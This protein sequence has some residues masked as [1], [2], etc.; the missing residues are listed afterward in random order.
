MVNFFHK[1]LLAF[2]LVLLTLPAWAQ[3]NN[4]PFPL[5]GQNASGAIVTAT[6]GTTAISEAN[7]YAFVVNVKD[8]GAKGDGST[9]DT[10]AINAAVTAAQNQLVTSNYYSQ[11]GIPGVYLPPGNYIT[12]GI[13]ISQPIRLYGDG[14]SAVTIT[15]K[16]GSNGSVIKS[17][18]NPLG[19]LSTWTTT[20][21]QFFGFSIN[22]NS[23][24]QTGTS[25]GIE[26]TNAP[27][28]VG[29]QYGV[30]ANI[31]NVNIQDALT[32]GVYVGTNRN[33]GTIDK[34]IVNYAQSDC[35]YF[36]GVSDWSVS[37]S[38]LG[39]CV[40]SGIVLY[41]ASAIT[42]GNDAIYNNGTHG[43]VVS[44][45]FGSYLWITGSTIG[46]NEG[47]GIH[48][49]PG[50]LTSG[51]VVGLSNVHLTDNSLANNNTNSHIYIRNLANMSL[52]NVWFYYQGTGNNVKYLIDNDNSTYIPVDNLMY[53]T[54]GGN[55]AYVTAAFG[56]AAYISGSTNPQGGIQNFNVP[57]TLNSGT[58]FTGFTLKTAGGGSVVAAI[59]GVAS[60]NDNGQL[61]LSS[62]GTQGVELNA[63]AASF[64]THGLTVGS[65][66][67]SP[68]NGLLTNGPVVVGATK[69]TTSGCSISATVGSGTSG[70]YTSGTTGTCTAVITMNGAT[71][72]T[73]PN[74][75]NCTAAD[76][77]TPADAQAQTANSTTTATIAGTTV[78]GDVVHFSCQAY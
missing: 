8:Y 53:A 20:P 3:P 71:G 41:F 26:L 50:T 59:Q 67:A 18:A 15:L 10:A 70:T 37:N 51:G 14:P 54:S 13:N 9:D 35:L 75:W 58:Q 17:A 60:S 52:S 36:S 6:G 27:Y 55:Q 7:R 40:G 34:V 62:G 45:G 4:G 66:G 64:L 39:A 30:G 11:V 65:N 63:A 44:S 28:S 22:G 56:N 42:L 24:N 5:A 19:N 31:E 38:S 46:A 76:W 21:S 78:S 77:T 25:N 69:F 32:K 74:G 73:A 16:A 29:T 68:A 61:Y 72:M 33:L 1:L 57:V 12:S 48:I 47:D 2:C 49:D 23:S 43:V